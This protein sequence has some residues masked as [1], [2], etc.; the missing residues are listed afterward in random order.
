MNSEYI[1]G[2]KGRENLD[3]NK[4]FDN[5]DENKGCEKNSMK[6]KSMKNFT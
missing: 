4:G 1:G 5:L 6:I 3:G 2:N